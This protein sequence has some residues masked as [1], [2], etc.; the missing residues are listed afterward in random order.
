MAREKRAAAAK[1]EG[2]TR[3]KAD[4]KSGEFQNFYIFSGEEAYLR[5]HYLRLL[6]DKLTGGPA[7]VFNEHRFTA[8]NLSPEA[9]TDAVEAMPM[10]ADRTF[11]RIDD[12]DFFKMAEGQRELYRA[13]LGDIPDYCTLVLAYDTVEFKINGTMKKLAEVFRRACLVE[14][15]KQSE[16]D[17]IAWIY[18]H[19]KAGGKEITDELCRYLIFITDGMMAS[20]GAEIQKIIHFCAGPVIEK[21]HIDAVVTPALSAQSFDISNAISDGDYDRALHKLQELFAMQEEPLLILGA[22]GAQMRRLYYAKTISDCGKTQQTLM[23]LTGLKSSYAAGLAM[24]AARRVSRQ[25][26][27]KA[28]ELCREAD[29]NIKTSADD[30]QRVLELLLLQLA[31]EVR[32]A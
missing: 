11:V 27:E 4:L 14:V 17:L 24:T 2:L 16:R 29:R 22:I 26:C 28:V 21:G 5:E 31:Q 19:F 13:I 32:R 20:L 7:G 18:R 1:P 10:M 9:L 3:L 12:V 23:E 15:Q 8:E 6:T 30:A 25:F